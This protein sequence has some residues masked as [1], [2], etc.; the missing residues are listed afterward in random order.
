MSRFNAASAYLY[1]GDEAA[2]RRMRQSAA[3]ARCDQ[4][5]ADAREAP[6]A[7]IRILEPPV[8]GPLPPSADALDRRIAEEIDYARRI[9][10]AMGDR[11]ASDGVI[12]ARH[13]ATLQGFDLVGQMLGHLAAVVGTADRGEAI[14][15]I[16][17]EDLR[18][19]LR[20][21]SLNGA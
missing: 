14:G 7:R 3:Q 12:V 6:G 10:E 17:M 21:R 1:P 16:G 2:V 8:R 18:A 5:Q 11:L 13:A 4:A 20:R 19:R 9:L 15:R